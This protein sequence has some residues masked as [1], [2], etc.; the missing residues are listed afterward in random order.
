MTAADRRW[1]LLAAMVLGAGMLL[2]SAAPA[3]ADHVD[4]D[5]KDDEYCYRID[6]NVAD[7]EDDPVDEDTGTYYVCAIPGGGGGLP[8]SGGGGDGD[9]GADAG[10]DTHGIVPAARI[11][12]GAGGTA[13]AG[14]PALLAAVLSSAMGAI[15]AVVARRRR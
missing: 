14:N 7:V 15:G 2:L 13:T 10:G 5:F 8:D 12:A 9:V 1:R 4:N 6:S 3:F 11:D